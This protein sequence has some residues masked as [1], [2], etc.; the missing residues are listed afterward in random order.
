[1]A[2]FDLE[3]DQGVCQSDLRSLRRHARA[4]AGRPYENE[5]YPISTSD[6][7]RLSG[8]TYL[9][10]LPETKFTTL[11]PLPSGVSHQSQQPYHRRIGP[12]PTIKRDPSPSR[13]TSATLSDHP[14]H[15]PY[16]MT[17]SLPMSP[18]Y[19]P[20]PSAP[21]SLFPSHSNTS[22]PYSRS[23]PS[24]LHPRNSLHSSRPG[25]PH[26]SV[27][28]VIQPSAPPMPAPPPQ[29]PI[30]ASTQ[31]TLHPILLQDIRDF[32][33]RGTPPTSMHYFDYP[34][35]ENTDVGSTAPRMGVNHNYNHDHSS[36]RSASTLTPS[37]ASPPE[38][39]YRPRGYQS[40]QF[41]QSQSRSLSQGHSYSPNH[42]SDY[43]FFQS[44]ESSFHIDYAPQPRSPFSAANFAVGMGGGG[45]VPV[46]DSSY[47]NLVEHLG[48][49]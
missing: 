45:G 15:S 37:P 16:S 44:M 30:S 21:I 3:F 46:T 14:A 12:H 5:G 20:T 47:Q 28:R 35:E 10:V 27:S 34:H 29:S 36:G 41:A 32:T 1:M 13:A 24:S 6:L 2:F 31:H 38:A 25:E 19:A 49:N 17:G 8:K 23:H 22:Y 33:M 26:S 40:P 18:P 48:F 11:D 43:S 4:A 39:S 9:L 7:E 42:E